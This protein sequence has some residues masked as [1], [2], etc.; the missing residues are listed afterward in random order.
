MVAW[1]W[2]I[3]VFF[4]GFV[5]GMFLTAL[6]RGSD[7]DN[8]NGELFIRNHTIEFSED[9]VTSR[10]EHG[11]IVRISSDGVAQYDPET[12]KWRYLN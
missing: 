5:G 9:C 8:Y 2:L 1:Y 7:N 10:D 12:G 4:F 3:V 11:N 6:L